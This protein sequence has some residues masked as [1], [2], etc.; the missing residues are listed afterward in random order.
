MP[1]VEALALPLDFALAL[2]G[3]DG[4]APKVGAALPRANGRL[5][6]TRRKKEGAV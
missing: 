1:Y 5:V 6:A 4:A 2:L 3:A